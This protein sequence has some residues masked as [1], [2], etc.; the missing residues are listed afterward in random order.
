MDFNDAGN[1]LDAILRLRNLQV[2]ESEWF[3]EAL[4]LGLPEMKTKDA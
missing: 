3:E 4:D 2:G 1:F